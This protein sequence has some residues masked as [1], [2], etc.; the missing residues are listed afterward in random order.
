MIKY[1]PRKH[2]KTKLKIL[3]EDFDPLLPAG[4]F[5]ETFVSL[6]HNFIFQVETNPTPLTLP[7]ETH[8][9]PRVIPG[10]PDSLPEKA[11]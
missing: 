9:E 2:T 6:A 5:P 8:I 7:L 3:R 4:E 10:Q 11:R 1:F